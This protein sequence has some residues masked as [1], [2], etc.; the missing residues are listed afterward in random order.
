MRNIGVTTI[1]FKK[2]IKM[3]SKPDNLSTRCKKPHTISLNSFLE[4]IKK[5]RILIFR[6]CTPSRNGVVQSKF[7]YCTF[8]PCYKKH[9]RD[10]RRRR[11]LYKPTTHPLYSQ[12]YSITFSIS[13]SILR[14]LLKLRENAS[15]LFSCP[16]FL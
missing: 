12:V 8:H 16:T 5:V 7:V 2:F 1:S 3:W 15:V 11:C 4:I 9:E 14:H 10:R 6:V 13:P